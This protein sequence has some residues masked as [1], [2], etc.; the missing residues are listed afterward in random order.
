[1]PKR[2]APA[3]VP[4]S[5]IITE[6]SLQMQMKYAGKYHRTGSGNLVRSWKPSKRVHARMQEYIFTRDRGICGICGKVAAEWWELDH[7]K[8]YKLG[9]L[10]IEWNLRLACRMCNQSRG[11]RCDR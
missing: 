8:P 3:M 10:Y 1:M 5:T 2:T 7:I 9:G 6:H 11:A 4:G